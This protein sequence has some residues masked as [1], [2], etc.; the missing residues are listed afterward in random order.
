MRCCLLSP[1]FDTRGNRGHCLLKAMQLKGNRAEIKKKKT[2]FG[3]QVL[4]HYAPQLLHQ[5]ARCGLSQEESTLSVNLLTDLSLPCGPMVTMGGCMV[6]SLSYLILTTGLQGDLC[7][8]RERLTRRADGGRGK[9][10]GCF[11]SSLS[12]RKQFS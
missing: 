6:A 10:D 3:T 9:L 7:I 12:P 5:Y 8:T 1:T 2:D 4:N 11:F